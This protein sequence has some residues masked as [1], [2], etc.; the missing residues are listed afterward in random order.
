MTE[1][2][3]NIAEHLFLRNPANPKAICVLMNR[4]RFIAAM[5]YP[6]DPG[7]VVAFERMIFERLVL[8]ILQSKK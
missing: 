4:A 6:H 5:A 8:A 1:T 3:S 7:K 2:I